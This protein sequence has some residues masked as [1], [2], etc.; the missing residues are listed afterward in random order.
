MNQDNY[1]FLLAKDLQIK[2]QIL[3]TIYLKNKILELLIFNIIIMQDNYGKQLNIVV[4]VQLQLVDIKVLH[5][6]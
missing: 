6:K 1:Q 5:K 3:K 2:I 4:L